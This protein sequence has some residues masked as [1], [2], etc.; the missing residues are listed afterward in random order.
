MLSSCAILCVR[1]VLAICQDLYNN[2]SSLKISTV[3]LRVMRETFKYIRQIDSESLVIGSR[4]HP[5][6]TES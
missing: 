1:I 2:T 3:R 5:L 4:R 6:G